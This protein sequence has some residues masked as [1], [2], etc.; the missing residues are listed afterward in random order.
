MIAS[1]ASAESHA[2]FLGGG[3]YDHFIPSVVDADST[4]RTQAQDVCEILRRASHLVFSRDGLLQHSGER[5]IDLGLRAMRTQ[6]SGYVGV[7]DGA[8]GYHWIEGDTL[9]HLPA[10]KITPVD[11]NG[12]GDAF[13]GAFALALARGDD[14]RTAA[15]FATLVATLKCTRPGSRDGLPTADGKVAFPNAEVAVS[16]LDYKFWLDEGIASRAPSD[17]QGFFKLARDAMKLYGD[18]VKRFTAPTEVSPGVQALPAPGH[19][20][21]HTMYRIS[22]GKDQLLIWGDIVHVQALQFARPGASLAFDSDQAQAAAT[23]K[24]VF[25]MSAKDGVMVAG[26][27]LSFPGLGY[28]ERGAGGYAYA[29]AQFAPVV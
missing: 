6:Y 10:P 29:P 26:M 2:C 20:I 28:V 17:M 5:K 23:R 7:T 21:G 4:T 3:A 18:R 8:H 13:H 11:T 14:E 24:R 25:D 19:T 1:N 9:V 27:H 22:S 15:K 16:E 12:A